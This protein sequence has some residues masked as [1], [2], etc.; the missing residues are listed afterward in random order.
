MRK[1][2]L[3]LLG[4]AIVHATSSVVAGSPQTPGD[5]NA[6]ATAVVTR[7][8]RVGHTVKQIIVDGTLLGEKRHV[9]VHLWYPADPVG[10]A[11]APK[12]FYSSILY[13]RPLIPGWDPLSWRIEADMAREQA[14]IDPAGRAFPVI[15]FSHGATND[16]ID[17]AYTLELVAA[18]GFVV[19]APAHVNNNQ[20]DV[21]IDFVNA[22]AARLGL[23]RVFGCR[24]GLPAPCARPT[25][26]E[27]W[28][29]AS[30]TSR[31]S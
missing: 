13:G 15:V 26:G 12:T 30:K 19:A 21:R 22:E 27:A 1:L 24:D 10:F 23:P 5:L 20:D 3:S 31:P 9:D 16:P 25:W 18:A 28:P 2:V 4:L 8:V 14:A 6:P 11:D 17:Y 7:D 29:T